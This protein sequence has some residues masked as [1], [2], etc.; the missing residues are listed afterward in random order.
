MQLRVN[1]TDFDCLSCEQQKLSLVVVNNIEIEFCTDCHG[2][3]FD[4]N[5]MKA[6]MP[7]RNRLKPKININKG[8]VATGFFEVLLALISD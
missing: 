7:T 1:V 2:V 4:F 3:Y 5:E 6:A 8:V